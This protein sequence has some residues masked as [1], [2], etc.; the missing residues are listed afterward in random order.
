MSATKGVKRERLD[1]G[2]GEKDISKIKVQ[3]WQCAEEGL[4]A[5]ERSVK[6]CTTCSWLEEK[7]Q[8]RAGG[9][10]VRTS[11]PIASSSSSSSSSSLSSSSSS[12]SSASRVASGDAPS[13]FD[14]QSLIVKYLQRELDVDRAGL[15][16]IK[17]IT[18][19]TLIMHR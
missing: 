1:D 15:N 11:L 4:P 5:Y 3:C 17:F 2:D 10:Q 13:E 16:L 9:S 6:A 14:L 18:E 12:S 8:F 7:L 19:Q